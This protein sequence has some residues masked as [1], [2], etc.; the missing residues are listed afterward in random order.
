MTFVEFSLKDGV[1]SSTGQASNTVHNDFRQTCKRLQRKH[2]DD[3]NGFVRL[4]ETDTDTATVYTWKMDNLVLKS[5]LD[6]LD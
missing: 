1:A 3:R 4:L 2:F 5:K 6:I